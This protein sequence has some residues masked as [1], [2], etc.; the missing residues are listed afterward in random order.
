MRRN[1]SFYALIFA[2]LALFALGAG[3]C[4]GG[5]GLASAVRLEDDYYAYVNADWLAETEI[6]PDEAWVSAFTE[7]ETEIRATLI[8]DLDAMA[9]GTKSADNPGI[10]MAV[11]YYRLFRDFDKRD[12]DGFAPASADFSRID[13]LENLAGL[14]SLASAWIYDV[15]PL[16]FTV[17]VVKD[18]SDVTRYIVEIG[19]GSPFLSDVSY[20]DEG[21]EEGKRRKGL[22]EEMLVELFKAAGFDDASARLET[23]SAMSFDALLGAKQPD[24]ETK[25]NSAYYNNHVPID[26]LAAKSRNIDFGLLVE[27]LAGERPG[28][29][30][31]VNEA[32]FDSFDDLYNEKNF[33]AMKSWLKAKFLYNYSGYL[34]GDFL[35]SRWRYY[36]ALDGAEEKTDKSEIAYS[37]VTAEFGEAIGIYYGQKYFG[38]EAREKAT[39]M[40]RDL[41]AVY[42]KRLE[43]NDWLGGATKAMAIRKLDAL[44]INVGYPDE[45]P[46]VYDFYSVTPHGDGG[47]VYGNISALGRAWRLHNFSLYGKTPDR[48]LWITS[49]YV[50]NAFYQHTDNSINFPA[51]IL[52]APFYSQDQNDSTNL[53]AI[54]VLMGHEVSHAFDSNGSLF[55]ENGSMKNWW[56]EEDAA[57]FGRR[58]DAMI[59]LFDGIPYGGGNVNGRL[60]LGENIADAGGLYC[61]LDVLKSKQDASLEEFFESYAILWRAKLRPEFETFLLTADPHAPM[62]LRLNVQLSNCDA[63]Y[64]T[65][66]IAETDD[67]YMTPEKRAKIW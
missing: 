65:Y 30:N 6:P 12:L 61:A 23:R 8:A 34:S 22:L 62:K 59:A 56:T 20:Y 36:A 3:G 49:G 46:P 28:V 66:D 64:E 2:A 39:G 54:G 33:A 13:A 17:E 58:T 5:G 25:E 7:I 55:D 11:E 38:P 44:Q 67:M 21:S 60:T 35:S 27:R 10:K 42:R 48:A 26:G 31:V 4:G 40:I 18:M 37:Y 32:F 53:G 47:T 52:N 45:L 1:S 63:F 41:V 14:S 15:M 16:P 57:E 43:D 24:A 29:V 51:G 9:S 19:M 50:V